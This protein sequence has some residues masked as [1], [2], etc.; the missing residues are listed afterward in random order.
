MQW[1]WF[2]FYIHAVLFICETLF[3]KILQLYVLLLIA[4]TITLTSVS[5]SNGANPLF[6]LT[7]SSM[8]LVL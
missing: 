4:E 7:K 3:E 2:Y 6:Q 8:S 1:H 5:L